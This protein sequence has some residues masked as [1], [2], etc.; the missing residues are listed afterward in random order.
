MFT[1]NNLMNDAFLKVCK[2][3]GFHKV[4]DIMDVMPIDKNGKSLIDQS[5]VSL[6]MNKQRK[7]TEE[8]AKI[9]QTI[10]KVHY[11]KIIDESIIKYPITANVTMK[12]GLVYPRGK[13]QHDFLVCGKQYEYSWGTNVVLSDDRKCVFIYNDEWLFSEENFIN[14][15]TQPAFIETKKD[16]EYILIIKNLDI[17]K[18]VVEAFSSLE[19]QSKKLE[20]VNIWPINE[21]IY[22]NTINQEVNVIENKWFEPKKY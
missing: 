12:S 19:N 20:Y 13:K 7:V 22:L 17:E 10:F 14:G 2:D 8:H 18:K 4:K 3:R 16:E 11:F 5:T 21:I 6:H 15:S 9:Y 1:F